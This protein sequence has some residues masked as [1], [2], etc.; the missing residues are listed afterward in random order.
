MQN[1]CKERL[2]EGIVGELVGHYVT[3]RFG[4]KRDRT[5]G[6]EM[7]TIMLNSVTSLLHPLL[8][9]HFRSMLLTLMEV[10][11]CYFS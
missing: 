4:L 9:M 11:R 1:T 8:R 7:C 2:N 5:A 10:Y 3:P 6:T